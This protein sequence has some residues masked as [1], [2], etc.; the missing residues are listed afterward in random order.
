MKAARLRRLR[1]LAASMRYAQGDAQ[2]EWYGRTIAALINAI[3]DE[4]DVAREPEQTATLAI[5]SPDPRDATLDN[6]RATTEPSAAPPA[7]PPTAIAKKPATNGARDVSRETRSR[8]QRHP[9]FEDDPIAV[10]DA[11]RER[12]K[13]SSTFSLRFGWRG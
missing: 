8:Q 13:Q 1:A 3:D 10:A 2:V 4:S 6:D 5:R 12:S 9:L 7:D 11:E